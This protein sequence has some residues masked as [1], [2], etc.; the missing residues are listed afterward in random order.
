[1]TRPMIMPRWFAILIL[2]ASSVSGGCAALTN[3]VASGVPVRRLPDE[4][5]SRPRAD[6]RA[7]PLTVLRQRENEAYL[8]DKGDVLAIIADDIIAPA[9]QQP[10]I[11]MPD[12]VNRT[13]AIGYPVPVNDDGT[14]SL[15]RLKPIDVRGQT[16]KQVETAIRNAA[17]EQ[18]LI[19]A[20]AVDLVRIG[21]QLLERRTYSITVVR[22][23]SVPV[24]QQGGQGLTITGSSKRGASYTIRL[25]AGE[26]DI[27]HAM[28]AA[29]GPPGLDAKNELLIYR[30]NYDPNDPTKAPLRIP[31]RIYPEQ[32]LTLTEADITLKDG[33]V[34]LIEARDT[35]LYYLAGV[36][37]SRQFQLPRDYDLDVIQ[38]L[39]I[40][41]A[42]LINGG[43]S[44][45]A[46]VAQSTA[47]GIGTPSPALVTV[48]RQLPNGT[49]IPIRVEI[50]RAIVDPRERIRIQP[51]DWIVMQERPG[52]ALLRYFYQTFPATLTT[53]PV[54]NPDF[55]LGVTGRVP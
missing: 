3:P 11:R 26:N 54:R 5:L 34:M 2:A 8:L 50:D 13:A 55:T 52:D 1:M 37:G 9:A 40:A 43:F 29:G 51:G 12:Q 20:N 30:G 25:P 16:L 32:S 19:R 49:Q 46:F 7:I 27:L 17:V 48:L 31:L 45:N 33:D 35:D 28:N 4:V 21:V 42:P 10:P 44:Q 14:I 53:N 38:A 23:D 41:G 6:L 18:K 15:P 39:A 36:G 22:E 24:Q 47:S